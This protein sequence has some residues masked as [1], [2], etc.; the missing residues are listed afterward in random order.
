[1]NDDDL[2][3]T[4]REAAVVGAYQAGEKLDD[5]QHRFGLARSTLYW[6]LHRHGVA[7]ARAKR[8]SRIVDDA[9]V[10]Q[11]YELIEHQDQR[12]AEA[13]AAMEALERAVGAVDESADGVLSILRAE[14]AAQAE[15]LNWWRTT[16]PDEQ[17]P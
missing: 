5:I 9:T 17:A 13:L 14:I 15:E 3:P 1:M 2:S 7:P 8:R 4:Q 16:H 6:I 11:L 10:E 12:I